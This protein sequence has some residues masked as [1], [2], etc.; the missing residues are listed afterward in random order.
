[1]S[2]EYP[3]DWNSRRKRVYRRDGHRCQNCGGKSQAGNDIQLNAHHIVPKS[4]GGTHQETNLITLCTDCHNAIHGN[5]NAP[6]AQSLPSEE[7]AEA[8]NNLLE[9]AF[10]LYIEMKNDQSELTQTMNQIW[11]RFDDVINPDVQSAVDFN[12]LFRRYVQ[13]LLD[14][15]LNVDRYESLD[16]TDSIESPSVFTA[17]SMLDEYIEHT[18]SHLKAGVEHINVVFVFVEELSNPEIECSRCGTLADPASDY[19]GECGKQLSIKVTCPSCAAEISEGTKFCT[20][21]GTDLQ[22]AELQPDR[23]SLSPDRRDELIDKF[24]DTKSKALHEGGVAGA[25]GDLVGWYLLEGKEPVWGNC[26]VCGFEMGVVKIEGSG[27][28]VL[29][30]SEWEQPGQSDRWVCVESGHLTTPNEK[31]DEDWELLASVKADRGEYHDYV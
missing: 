19:C 23:A 28:C 3:S 26:P 15:Q 20:S 7:H 31:S 8:P 11:D 10:Q 14:I 6:T 16:W 17:T 25:F 24:S 2:K 4:K 9:T 1:M 5:R 12:N 22:T 30:R 27:L 13:L 18:Q 21:C 29:C